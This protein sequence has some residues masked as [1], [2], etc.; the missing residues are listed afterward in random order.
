MV[1]EKKLLQKQNKERM[2]FAIQSGT[3]EIP[4]SDNPQV[5]QSL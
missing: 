1:G 3:S 5:M 2:N 4:P